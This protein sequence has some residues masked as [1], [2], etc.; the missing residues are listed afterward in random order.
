[1][2][3]LPKDIGQRASSVVVE[4]SP[5]MP[6]ATERRRIELHQPPFI[7]EADIEHFMGRIDDR[8][9]MA[10]RALQSFE[11]LLSPGLQALIS[12]TGPSRPARPSERERMEKRDDIEDGRF[13]EFR[14][15]LRLQERDPDL[16]VQIL[17]LPVPCPAIRERCP[18]Q[19]RGPFRCAVA[20]VVEG[21]R[22]ESVGVP[23]SVAAMTTQEA[24]S[25]EAGIIERVFTS[26][27]R[28]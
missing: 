17:E 24:S 1:M 19:G 5:L 22:Q 15:V 27:L 16:I 3:K 8:R 12:T 14:R 26:P 11:E 4:E 9:D 18:P 7:S 20:A 6:D 25:R 21:V 28:C 23:V 2:R 10:L 13:F